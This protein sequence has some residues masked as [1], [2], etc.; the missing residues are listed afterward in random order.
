[1]KKIGIMTLYYQNHN[2]GGQLQAYALCRYLNNQPDVQCEQ[3]SFDYRR[4]KNAKRTAKQWLFWLYSILLHPRV[5]F[6]LR[7]RKQK[8]LTFEQEIPHSRTA[9]KADLCTLCEDYDAVIVG[10][11]QVWN[12]D[13]SSTCFLLQFVP[14]KKRWAY[15][16][17]FG[18]DK[19]QDALDDESLKA[20]KE[21]AFLSVREETAKQFLEK[22]EV[23]NVEV[24]CDPTLLLSCEDWRAQILRRERMVEGN[25]LFVYL[26]SANP[27]ARSKIKQKAA[28]KGLKIVFLPHIHFTYQKRDS[29]FADEEL[30]DVGPWEFL[31][32]IDDATAIVTDSFHCS[33]FSIL[34]HKNF[35]TLRREKKGM[36]ETSG[37]MKTLLTKVNQ[38]D[39]FVEP[40]AIDLSQAIDYGSVDHDLELYIQQ[41]R[42]L[43]QKQLHQ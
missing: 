10:S 9:E 4:G 23:K 16:A 5:M 19:I 41:S 32:L 25:Y 6:G 28:E 34:F 24:V 31:R 17:S 3:I 14:A 38:I 22:N 8:F 2:Y 18:K 33:L 29:G 35:W 30:Y 1:M 43:L 37:R 36:A 26:L 27:Q 20:L 12:F 21:F 15:A 13:Y 11:D 7:Q 40:D 42:Q 39:R